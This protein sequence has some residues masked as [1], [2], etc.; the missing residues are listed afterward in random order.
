MNET[1]FYVFGIGLT[2][3]ALIVTAIGLKWDN[4][5]G[6]RA[7]MALITAVF[8]I[9]VGG[10]AVFGW[11]NAEDEQEHREHELAEATEE[12]EAEGN[13][14][15]AGEEGGDLSE[16]PDTALVD[17]GATVFESEGCAGCH[18]F[19][20]ADATGTTG[21]ALDST[22]R[23]KSPEYIRTQIVDPNDVIVEGYP[24]D[25]MPQ[26]YEELPP[27]ELDGLVQFLVEGVKQSTGQ[28][29]PG[30]GGPD[31]S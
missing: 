9:G 19:A 31:N 18:T 5:P 6:N 13:E 23:G 4:F 30:G 15:E 29:A 11:A 7:V 1:L 14:A 27:E 26:T 8:V 22:L 28:D 3:A 12:N 16:P 17:L 10:T 24:P 20:A 2:A 25:V 21:P